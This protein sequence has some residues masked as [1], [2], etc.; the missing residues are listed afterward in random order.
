M[1]YI[2]AP[3]D[4]ELICQ[5][6]AK[7][8]R[9]F[10]SECD[11]ALNGR[12]SRAAATI[13]GKVKEKPIVLLAGPSGSGKTTTAG[14]LAQELEWQG[15]QTHVIS[16]DDYFRTVDPE[17]HPKDKDG[18]I[19]YE[20]PLCMDGDLLTEHFTR[21]SKGFEVTIPHYDFKTQSSIKE[22][23]RQLRLG[24]EEI[25]IF[26]GIH[27]LNP[28]LL[29]D[30]SPANRITRVYTSA[31][32]N[33]R[34]DK[35]IIFKGTWMRLI[36][37]VIRDDNFRGMNAQGT[38][39]LWANVRRGEKSYISPYKDRADIT[40]DTALGYEVS[41]LKTRALELFEVVPEGIERT[42][43]LREIAPA[44]ELFPSLPTEWIH[45]RSLI[46]EFIGGGIL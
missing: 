30:N 32:A 45:K 21:L 38:M 4:Y 15:I 14:K 18:N 44:L 25:A 27:A 3:F 43:E 5:A 39:H 19:D 12:I 41:A 31:R 28:L 26:E 33:I 2:T 23:G 40:I 20:S 29:E 10:I 16:M 46:R 24:N 11:H 7:D 13:A 17:T 42:A 8:P 36:R 34:Q 1:S 22:T 37:R 9:G 6:A 35:K